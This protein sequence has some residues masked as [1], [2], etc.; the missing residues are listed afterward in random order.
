MPPRQVRQFNTEAF[1][2]QLNNKLSSMASGFTKSNLHDISQTLA[3][4]LRV[5]KQPAVITLSPKNAYFSS[6]LWIPDFWAAFVHDGRKPIDLTKG[7]SRGRYSTG[8]MVL[9]WFRNPAD[10]PRT[11]NGTW[12][13]TRAEQVKHLTKKQWLYWR[14][15]NKLARSRGMLEPM[16]VTKYSGKVKPRPFFSNKD[17]LYDMSPFIREGRAMA[18]EF[19]LQKIHRFIGKDMNIKETLILK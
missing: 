15:Q 10:D 14:E 6:V 13:P 19:S 1:V 2:K 16:I 12:Y 3:K 11:R 8:K 4:H 18:L 17:P 7:P 9:V 5:I